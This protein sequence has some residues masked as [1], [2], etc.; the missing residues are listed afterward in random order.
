LN[1]VSLLLFSLAFAQGDVVYSVPSNILLSKPG[2]YSTLIV[3]SKN[4]S[5]FIADL[6]DE[7]SAR[8]EDPEVA[9]VF[10]GRVYGKKIGTTRAFIDSKG[11]QIASPQEP[12]STTEIARLGAR[13]KPACGPG[14]V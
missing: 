5:G 10:Q 4:A 1:T 8:I 14:Q 11:K 2:S 13:G 12:C 7:S 6:T 9:M 3:E